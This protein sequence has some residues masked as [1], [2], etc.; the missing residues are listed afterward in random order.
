[1][2]RSLLGQLR[3]PSCHG[4]LILHAYKSIAETE[5]IDGLLKCD[6]GASFLLHEGVPCMEAPMRLPAAYSQA[7]RDALKR[8]APSLAELEVEP[9]AANFSFSWQW[10]AHLYDDLTW[11]LRLT[12]RVSLF[13]RYTGLTP[14]E[15][16]GVRLLDAG[17]GNGTLSAALASEGFEVVG[18]DRSAG[19]LRAFKYQWFDSLVTQAAA[20]RLNYVQGDLQQP[21]FDDGEFDL[22]YSD[23][24]MHHTPD[25]KRT[26][27]AVS[28]KVKMGGRLFIWLY[29]SDTRGLQALKIKAVKLVRFVTGRMSYAA[30]WRLCY[31]GALIIM[32][33]VRLLRLFGWHGRP[34]IPVRQKAINLFDTIT[35]TF[36]HEHTPAEARQ[37][38]E[39]AGFSNIQEVSIAEF[40]LAAGGF[41]MIG[42][43]ISDRALGS[44]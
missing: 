15:V 18:L 20:A 44:R 37:W 19:A 21:P 23:G 5:V 4:A 32:T 40:R 17:C 16:R 6:C 9:P 1:M 13:Y 27:L 41:A 25:T 35:P 26:F 7:Y 11:E 8:D 29:R 22:I 33:G 24:V 30:R 2:K 42:T 34:A 28:R 39:E 43:R 10:N 3:C 14:R 12:Q 38:F 31:A 36:N